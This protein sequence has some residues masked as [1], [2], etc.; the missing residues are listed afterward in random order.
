[1]D[2]SQYSTHSLR[3]TKPVYMYSKPDVTIE[4]LMML[5][6]HKSPESTIRYLGIDIEQAQKKAIKYD[7]FSYGSRRVHGN[8]TKTHDLFNGET[9]NEETIEI[10]A[11]R[12]AELLWP[13]LKELFDKK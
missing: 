11:E 2:S 4:D 6:G 5:L 13:K 3:R 12:V 9:E 1:M 10:L 8:P 7:L